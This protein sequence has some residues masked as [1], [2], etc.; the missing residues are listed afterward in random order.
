MCNDSDMTLLYSGNVAP[1]L[2]GTYDLDLTVSG[3]AGMA[4]RTIIG[5]ARVNVTASNQAPSEASDF[6]G[7]RSGKRAER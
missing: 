5:R 2:S 3:D 7:D 1:L 6:H 4:N